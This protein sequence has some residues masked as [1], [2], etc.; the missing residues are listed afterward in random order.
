MFGSAPLAGV[1]PPPAAPLGSSFSSAAPG[2]SFAAPGSSFALSRPAPSLP[3]DSAF[4]PDFADPSA[5][6]PEPPLA[7]TVPDCLC[8]DPEDVCLCC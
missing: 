7:L 1:P 4:D 5:L 8:G 3:D 6:G 2:P